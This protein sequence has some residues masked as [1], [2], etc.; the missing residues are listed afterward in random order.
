VA[1]KGKLKSMG[2]LLVLILVLGGLVWY[3]WPPKKAESMKLS[4]G[5][6]IKFHTSAEKLQIYKDGTWQDFFVKGVN[7]GAAIPG[8]DPGELAISKSDYLRWFLMIAEM[9][10]NT[11]RIY[12]I[13]NPVFYEAIVEYNHKHPELPLYYIQ[14]IWSPEEAFIKTKDAL[15]PIAIAAFKAEI[16]DAVHAVYGTKTLPK[17]FGK[18]SGS[19]LVNAGEYLLAWHTGTEWDPQLVK[20][21]NKLHSSQPLYKGVFFQAKT[22]ASPFESLLAEMIDTVAVL[23]NKEGWQHPQTFTNWVTTDPLTH[24]GEVLYEED[25]VSVDPMHIKPVNWAAGY[26]A[27]YH[28]Y[29]YYPDFFLL[30]KSLQTV[31]NDKGEIDTYKAY[32]KQLKA[33]HPGIPLMI[34]EFGVPSSIGIAHI[35]SLGRDQG[36]HNEQEQG[37]IDADLYHLIVQ[38]HMAGGILFTW[39]DEWFK[40]TWNTM[41]YEIP[42]DRRKLWLNVLTNEKMFGVLAMDPSKSTKL[43]IDGNL[44]DW[45]KLKKSDVQKVDTNVPGLK[46][47]RITHDE[48]Y[49]YIA[50]ELNA[51]F[52]SAQQTLYLG[53]DTINGGNRHA[54]QMGDYKLDEGLETLITISTDKESQVSIAS[55]Y[56]FLTRLYGIKYK[57]FP[58]KEQSMKDDSGLFDPW[59]LAT[60]LKF[61]PPDSKQARPFEDVKAGQLIRGTTDPTDPQFNS[62]ALLQIKGNVVEMRIPW[63]LLGFTDPSSLSVMNYPDSKG[64]LN[65]T[66]TKGIRLVPWIVNRIDN[67][68]IGLDEEGSIYPVSKLPLYTWKGWEEAGFSEREKESYA[69]IKQAFAK[70]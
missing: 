69:S 66:P 20:N 62:S 41:Y 54:P 40:K 13:Q 47:L 1:K 12:T 42:E 57:M 60:G 65:N 70:N 44:K 67:K 29:P 22:G 26:F 17:Q 31:R 39:Q 55:N 25:L 18:A 33:H 50:A 3:Y 6:N 53:V 11:I 51:D 4:N 7:L 2:T 16:S 52:K 58:V 68:V 59:M 15:S 27:S 36:G 9:G 37:A 48:G 43:L 56:N 45:D 30:D 24:P 61:N 32:L 64:S 23:E 35:G 8:H 28:V 63:M 21:T 38:E 49:V 46:G 19:Y 5:I 10:A 14:G 34:T